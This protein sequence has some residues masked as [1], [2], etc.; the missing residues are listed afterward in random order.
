M[1][2]V[3]EQVSW[4]TRSRPGET[5]STVQRWWWNASPHIAWGLDELTCNAPA[6]AVK[7]AGRWLYKDPR[8]YHF[9]TMR[10][11]FS[12][13]RLGRCRCD[14]ETDHV[15]HMHQ[16]LAAI[17]TGQHARDPDRMVA[18]RFDGSRAYFETY[19]AYLEDQQ[20]VDCT[21]R[22]FAEISLSNEGR[23]ILSMLWATSAGSNID[24]SP[25]AALRRQMEQWPQRFQTSIEDIDW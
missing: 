17:H 24:C 13:F 16:S 10:E 22:T 7:V 2:T 21:G 20:I 25:A 8:G 19:M 5:A 23:S 1:P 14:R 11:L 15:E 6:Q 12:G 9:D 18:E 3:A 4:L